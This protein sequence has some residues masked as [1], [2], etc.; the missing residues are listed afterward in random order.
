M[1]VGMP[2]YC[3]YIF[4]IKLLISSMDIQIQLLSF[5]STQL[6]SDFAF[7]QRYFITFFTAPLF[8][9]FDIILLYSYCCLVVYKK[10]IFSVW[11]L[12]KVHVKS[13]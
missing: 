4:T 11:V 6:D 13:I 5:H 2:K 7:Y 10:N 9:D 8:C 12:E 3:F 1:W